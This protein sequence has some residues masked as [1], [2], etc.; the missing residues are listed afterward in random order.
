MQLKLKVPEGLTENKVLEIINV[1]VRYLAPAFKFGYYDVDDMKQEGRC[2]CLE[3]LSDF[4]M[5]RSTQ[6]DPAL[7]LMTFF[8]VHVRRRF[9]NLR[10]DKFER[11]EPPSCDC[12]LCEEDS[13]ERLDCP[14]YSA[15]VRR[16]MAKRSLV[17]P[18]D[19]TEVY[20][21][22]SGNNIDTAENVMSR[23]VIAALDKH[24]PAHSRGDYK[25]LMEGVRLSK[26]KRS[27]VLEQIRKTLSEH[28]STEAEDWDFE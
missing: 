3:A 5:S 17:E 7:A 15:W 9:I 23:E 14:K 16:N 20:S 11:V 1:V 2:F 13:S 10:R 6:T 25:R 19:V 24:M 8:K 12:R 18:L 4:D 28:F 22:E 21:R 26:D 27:K